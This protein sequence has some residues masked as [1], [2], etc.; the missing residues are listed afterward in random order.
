MSTK[1]KTQNSLYLKFFSEISFQ[2][3]YRAGTH[4]PQCSGEYEEEE[5]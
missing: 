2:K 5:E 1:K 3:A 4:D